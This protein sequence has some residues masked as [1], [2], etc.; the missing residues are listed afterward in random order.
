MGD[1]KMFY[2]FFHRDT[3]KKVSRQWFSDKSLANQ[4]EGASSISAA[5]K[6]YDFHGLYHFSSKSTSQNFFQKTNDSQNVFSRLFYM[7]TSF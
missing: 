5:V 2:N 7:S 1:K 4:F 6:K 3:S